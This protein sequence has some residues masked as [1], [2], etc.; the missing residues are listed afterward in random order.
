[1]GTR[2]L[3]LNRN[4]QLSSFATTSEG[5]FTEE[6]QSSFEIGMKREPFVDSF[7]NESISYHEI[8]IHYNEVNVRL[9]VP[10]NHLRPVKFGFLS[11]IG[12]HRGAEL[13]S[14]TSHDNIGVHLTSPINIIE[15]FGTFDAQ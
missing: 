1:M 12:H 15:I 3:P 13:A 11:S 4:L 2:P 10:L 9:S 5:V 14:T 6:V 7:P 8:A